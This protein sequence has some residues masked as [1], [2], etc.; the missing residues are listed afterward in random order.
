MCV[1]ACVRVRACACEC[2]CLS[3]HTPRAHTCRRAPSALRILKRRPEALRGR[4]ACAFRATIT[5]TLDT[6]T[7]S[8]GGVMGALTSRRSG[9]RA[10]SNARLT[11]PHPLTPPLAFAVSALSFK[12]YVCARVCACLHALQFTL[13]ACTHKEGNLH[14]Q[15]LRVFV[16]GLQ[17][18]ASQPP[19]PAQRLLPLPHPLSL[20]P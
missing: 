7:T 18:S 19:H 20:H 6:P 13:S 3:A 10:A 17:A 1:C 12:V 11:P 14:T 8:V 4:S 9:A 16:C 15:E 5:R 2:V